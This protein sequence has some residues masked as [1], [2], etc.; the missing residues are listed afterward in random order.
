VDD[1]GPILELLQQGRWFGALDPALQQLIL[2]RSRVVRFEPGDCL[3]E[4]ASPPK[5]LYAVLEG[6]VRAVRRLADG[7][8]APVHVGGRGF[9]C[10]EYAT[11]AGQPSI[12]SAIADSRVR[13][14]FL[15]AAEFER[16]VDEEPRHYRAFME[17]LLERYA[18]V[19]GSVAEL[20]GLPSEERL[21]RRLESIAALW[22][23]DVPTSG[24]VDIPLSQLE[25]ASMVGLS[26]QRLSTLL[27]R[28]E[29]QGLIEAG[30]RSIRVLG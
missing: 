7:R 21:R 27:G 16:I 1:R 19:F 26:R 12:G 24:P 17:L 3:I 2:Q 11:L 30:F 20:H 29:A 8:D 18:R 6:R 9:W 28:L 22:R 15:S 25:L 13:A 23:D 10:G 4:E 5:G 14:L